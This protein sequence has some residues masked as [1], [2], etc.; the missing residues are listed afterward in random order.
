MTPFSPELPLSVL[1]SDAYNNMR[2][3]EVP[4][5]AYRTEVDNL[6]DGAV[7][8]NAVTIS[9]SARPGATLGVRFAH[10]GAEPVDVAHE[11]V[12]ADDD[13]FFSVQITA[14]GIPEGVLIRVFSGE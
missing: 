8:E 4:V 1:A 13:G 11:P 7:W 9:G 5:A 2:K 10:D 3:I 12:Q 6:S 14:D